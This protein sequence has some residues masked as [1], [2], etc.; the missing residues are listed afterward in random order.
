MLRQFFLA[1]PRELVEAARMD[2]L[3]WWGVFWKIHLPLSR[4][5]LI[6]PN[7]AA[8][9]ARSHSAATYARPSTSW[10]PLRSHWNGP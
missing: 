5:A 1:V 3:G 7:P 9:S 8:S 2:G 6:A 10:P 4:P